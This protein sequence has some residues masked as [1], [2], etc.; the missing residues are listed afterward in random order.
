M[1]AILG[2][3]YIGD[4]VNDLGIFPNN[5]NYIFLRLQLAIDSSPSTMSATKRGHESVR[6]A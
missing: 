2:V 3:E 1:V 4:Q 6:W 5:I